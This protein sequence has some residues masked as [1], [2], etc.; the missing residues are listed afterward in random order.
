MSIFAVGRTNEMENQVRP[1]LLAHARN[2][3]PQAVS[4]V[5]TIALLV[6]GARAQTL[7]PPN[8]PAQTDGSYEARKQQAIALYRQNRMTEA[9][10]LLEKLHDEKPT[11]AAVLGLLSFTVLANSATFEQAVES[12]TGAIHLLTTRVN[13]GQAA[14]PRIVPMQHNAA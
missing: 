13:P 10:P 5:L 1:R 11:D 2:L 7:T 3:L 4:A 12:L 9:M 6:P 8:P 14:T